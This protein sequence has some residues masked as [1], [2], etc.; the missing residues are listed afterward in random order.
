MKVYFIRILRIILI[1]IRGFNQDRASLRASALTFYSLLSVVPVAAMIFAF[2]K[3]FGFE[4]MLERELLLKFP[5]HK[6]VVVQIVGF[7]TSMLEHTKG[8]VIAGVGVIF[9]F[10]T[11]I[12]VLGNIEL[13]FNDI[14]NIG[15]QRN[16][17]RKL[18]DYLSIMLIA[19][20]FFIMSSAI[21]VYIRTEVTNLAQNVGPLELISPLV[22]FFLNFLPYFMI[23]ILFTF[24]Y[25]VMPNTKVRL[26]S[27]VTAAVVAGTIYQVTQI[28]YI[29]FQVGVSK[30]NAVYGSFAALPLFLIWLQLSWMIVLFGAEIS[31]AVQNED[32]FEF[33]FDSLKIS[34]YH[35]RLI[36]L[37]IAQ[38]VVKNFA[39]GDKALTVP[40]IVNKLGIPIRL[41]RRILDELVKSGLF[42]TANTDEDKELAYQPASDINHFTVSH[43]IEKLEKSG[44]DN[45]P[46]MNSQELKSVEKTLDSFAELIKKS[47]NNQLLVDL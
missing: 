33:E 13:S 18:S 24:I 44:S 5:E 17:V 29:S 38:L 40:E 47:P 39:N 27:G 26:I 25:I 21:T 37:L 12:K 45:V 11:V 22:F 10:W 9:L 35:K 34:S 42:A 16:F 46:V 28:I 2:A 1:S 36:S 20:I 7:A 23:W 8:G 19:P 30:Y 43:I 32:T 15:R 3:G 41:G 14:W 4:K 31:F 6:A